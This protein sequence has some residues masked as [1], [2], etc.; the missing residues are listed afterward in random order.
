MGT[1]TYLQK[2]NVPNSGN[3]PSYRSVNAIAT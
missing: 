1:F 3:V 2:V